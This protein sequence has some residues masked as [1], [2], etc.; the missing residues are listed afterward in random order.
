MSVLWISFKLSHLTTTLHV[1]RIVRSTAIFHIETKLTYGLLSSRLLTEDNIKPFVCNF[2]G[3]RI[4]ENL[5][6]NPDYYEDL[7]LLHAARKLVPNDLQVHKECK[8]V[9][10]Y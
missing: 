1:T 8:L 4:Q 3:K 7:L 10:N 6:S 2:V 5:F 9:L